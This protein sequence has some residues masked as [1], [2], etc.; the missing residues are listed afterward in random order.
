[1]ILDRSKSY[2]SIF[3]DRF[4]VDRSLKK[5][6]KKENENNN[7]PSSVVPVEDQLGSGNISFQS[8]VDHI[9]GTLKKS[10]NISFNNNSFPFIELNDNNISLS[11]Q[12]EAMMLLGETK[13]KKKEPWFKKLF[14]KR[15]KEEKPEIDVFRFFSLVKLATE[16]SR[17]EYIDRV[18]P[19]LVAITQA[20]N[21]GQTAL[22]EK[23]LGEL[24][25]NKYES[26]L[27]SAGFGKR[28]TESQ[29]VEFAKKSEKGVSLCYIK[30]F[31]RPIPL[32]VAKKKEEADN[33][34]VFDNYCVLYY[35]TTGKMS[36][37]TAIEKEEE[38]KKKADPILFGMI[39]NVRALY[40]IA[41]WTD[42][43]CDLTL[44][45]FLKTSGIEEQTIEMDKVIKLGE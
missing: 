26:I 41:D 2:L 43:Y 39:K 42:P 20:Q 22:V 35:D 11:A 19:F 1:M 28:I 18:Q 45:E 24:V 9:Y 29:L 8:I 25:V 12:E 36:D 21:L 5:F 27:Y 16:E 15:E 37:K 6:K 13:E 30:N 40:Y 34:E 17:L 33:L 4:E 14:K 23:L 3:V 31:T 7:L 32:E 10:D 38:R 44:K